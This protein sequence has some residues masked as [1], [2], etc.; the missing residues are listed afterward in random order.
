MNGMNATIDG[1]INWDKR[2]HWV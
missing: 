2:G 1:M